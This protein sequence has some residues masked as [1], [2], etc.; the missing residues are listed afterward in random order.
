MTLTDPDASDENKQH[1]VL[2][3]MH[4]GGERSSAATLFAAIQW[5][6]SD[7]P[8]AAD[9]LRRQ[10]I[11]CVPVVHPDGYDEGRPE[12]GQEPRHSQIY[13]NWN[14]KGV[15]DPETAPEAGFP[16]DF[17]EDDRELVYWG[18]AIDD[19]GDKAWSGRPSWS[20]VFF[21]YCIIYCCLTGSNQL[22]VFFLRL[23]LTKYGISQES[24]S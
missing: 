24:K 1:V 11:V 3:A 12:P 20:A 14:A 5:L 8:P 10:V 22:P 6:L 15:T 23:F 19:I 7:D 16:S 4:T 21:K 13:S 18:P 9:V 2:S 17:Q